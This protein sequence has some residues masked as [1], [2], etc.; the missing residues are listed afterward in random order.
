MLS[1]YTVLMVP[2]SVF[3]TSTGG[4]RSPCEGFSLGET[5]RFGSLEF[6]ANQF[7]GMSLS[8]SG[9]ARAPSSWSLFAVSHRSCSKP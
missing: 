3:I 7:N 4:E 9:T 6:I 5:I 8:P 2:S 1:F